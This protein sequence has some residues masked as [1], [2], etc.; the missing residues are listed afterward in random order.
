MKTSRTLLAALVTVAGL[1]A[2]P[3]MAQSL[4]DSSSD[5]FNPSIVQ[6]QLRAQGYNVGQV[7][8]WGNKVQATI[9][10]A[11]G[12]TGFAYFDRDTLRPVGD[13][14]GGNTRVLSR[15][16]VGAQPRALPDEGNA[17]LTYIDPD[18]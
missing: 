14:A 12:S 17:S 10:L 2:V 3:A 18:L 16:D 15:L 7:Q 9:T 13:Q 4:N 5:D 6:Q 1:A 11:D 8:D